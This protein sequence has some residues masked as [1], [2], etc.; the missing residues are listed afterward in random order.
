MPVLT[1][2]QLAQWRSHPQRRLG[3]LAVWRPALVLK[4]R[5]NQTAFAYPLSLLSFDDPDSNGGSTSDV[6]AGMT[7]KFYDGSTGVFKGYGRVL[8]A[9]SGSYLY[10]HP[11]GQ[12]DVDF[13][14]NDIIEI[15]DEYRP[16]AL[17]PYI[18][19]NGV[20]YKDYDTTYS[21][22]TNNFP[23][24]ANA[25]PSTNAGF[26]DSTTGKLT[27]TFD[28]AGT[29]PSYTVA[30]GATISSYAW[31]VKDGTITSG[32][33][34]SAAITVEFPAGR[35]WVKLTVTDSNS[36][37]AIKR[38]PIWAADTSD[39][40]PYKAVLSRRGYTHEA[41]WEASFQLLDA[42]LSDVSEHALVIFWQ[43]EYF[44]PTHGSLWSP[45]AFVGWVVSEMLHLEPLWS[46]SAFNASGPIAILQQRPAFPQT[47]S[48]DATPANWA[49]VKNLDWW[50]T[51]IYLLRFHTNMLELCDMERPGFY[52]D[53]PVPR[54]DA[55][56][57]TLYSQ[58]KFLSDAVFAR[59]TAD[60]RGRLYLRRVPHYMSSIERAAWTPVLGLAAS[61]IATDGQ[62]PEFEWPQWDKLAW[63]RS[64]AIVADA[65]TS[66]PVLA[67]APGKT[68]AQGAEVQTLDRLLVTSQSDLNKRTGH[69]YAHRQ[70][71]RD[72]ARVAARATLTLL[73]SGDAV[74]PALQEVVM[75]TLDASTNRR[76][77]A[78]S[79]ARFV[80]T[81][82]DVMY[83][84]EAFASIERLTLEEETRGA[85]AATEKVPTET[86]NDYDPPVYIPP[87][88][89]DPIKEE[90]TWGSGLGHAIVG[91][92][93]NL[94]GMSPP[95][96]YVSVVAVTNS[97]SASPPSWSLLMNGLPDDGYGG[98]TY[99]TNVTTNPFDQ[100]EALLACS[101]GVYRNTDWRNGGTW[102]Q[103]VSMSDILSA[104]N[105]Y[106][107]H[108]NSGTPEIVDIHFS[109]NT[110]GCFFMLCKVPY[111]G[112]FGE[113][114]VFPVRVL[115]YGTSVQAGP[116]P[117]NRN[118]SNNAIV[119]NITRGAPNLFDHGG[120]GI[121]SAHDTRDKIVLS[122]AGTTPTQG[123]QIGW[124]SGDFNSMPVNQTYLGTKYCYTTCLDQATTVLK[125]AVP[126]IP[127]TPSVAS[128]ARDNE[129]FIVAINGRIYRSTDGGSNFSAWSGS[130]QYPKVWA[131]DKN[132]SRDQFTTAML[133]AGRSAYLYDDGTDRNLYIDT[134]NTPTT[135][136]AKATPTTG[137]WGWLGGFPDKTSQFYIGH[138]A[139]GDYWARQTASNPLMYLTQ[140]AGDTWTNIT[141]NLWSLLPTASGRTQYVGIVRMTPHGREA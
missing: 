6:E 40:A 45:T 140:D 118:S 29:I 90:T 122:Q 110:E 56:L 3:H 63:L 102:S 71:T 135:W 15:Y 31:D 84:H 57:G 59:F 21:N 127:Y 80:P 129:V 116:V 49:E 50:K 64:S 133:S 55:E 141:G 131:H 139:R 23:P 22:Q 51:V 52:A 72:G 54:L 13:A 121:Q 11:T 97:L 60:K 9:I 37:T 35:R 86:V 93:V 65:S 120:C 134:D 48:S 4:R 82:M 105:T 33:S 70:K 66:T 73:H 32:S 18:D 68:P 94:R 85:T 26:V 75:L 27:V 46:D 113:G 8:R 39:Y 5:I 25:N 38:V 103:I 16:Y 123:G 108:T 61:D 67:I 58:V 78:W 88:T 12:G 112:Y 95:G 132:P 7:I 104:W 62:G 91:V 19:D 125:G 41:G 24:V 17:V 109:M 20:L 126:Y 117:V 79:E 28:A 76:G 81:G 107:G 14:D 124:W 1:A 115:N 96:D 92:A 137:H 89:I 106:Q 47:V 138:T 30:N 101:G 2:S 136:T 128:V 44:G 87:P 53:Y 77:K 111:S 74:D 10:I 119:G 43:D 100:D 99:I 98:P 130:G 42:D 36:A 34:T 114:L 69:V 83:D